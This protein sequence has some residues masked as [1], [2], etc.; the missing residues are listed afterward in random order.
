MLTFDV[1][2]T[3]VDWHTSIVEEGRRLGER[4][5]LGEMDWDAFAL[6]WRRRYGP[7]MQP[8]R[9]G[10]RPW[11]RL[12]VLHRESLIQTLDEFG[13]DGLPDADIDHFN[14]AWHRL[15]PWPDSPPGLTR[16]AR[17]FVIATLSNGHTELIVNMARHGN[18]PWNVVLGAEPTQRYKPHPETYSRS[19][20]IMGLAPVECM[21]VA[22][23]TG[24]L[25]AAKAVGFRTAYI[26][27]PH[28]LGEQRTREMPDTGAYDYSAISLVELAE[29]LGC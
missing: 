20:E 15:A 28:E 29:Q 21:M 23:H 8:I 13:I 18:L 10:T 19:A 16:L 9:E 12:D 22:A 17:R 3:V 26:H 2:G 25:D 27:R 6:A 24:D 1:F 4:L 14:R 5:E 11:V 7:S